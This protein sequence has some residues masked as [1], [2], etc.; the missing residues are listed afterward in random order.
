MPLG[1]KGTAMC[2]GSSVLSSESRSYILDKVLVSIEIVFLKQLVLWKFW[3]N[4][5]LNTVCESCFLGLL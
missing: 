5:F 2:A 1:R 4:T 3:L